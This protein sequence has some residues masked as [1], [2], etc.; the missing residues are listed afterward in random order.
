MFSM[1]R[2]PEVWAFKLMAQ[3][4]EENFSDHSSR[5]F[6]GHIVDMS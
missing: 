6:G 2:I 1:L 3:L 5:V 4:A